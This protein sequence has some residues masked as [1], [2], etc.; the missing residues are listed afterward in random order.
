MPAE[1]TVTVQL[2][3]REGR[4]IEYR[5]L[6]VLRRSEIQ[7]K[8]HRLAGHR[9]DAHP[10]GSGERIIPLPTGDPAATPI[11]RRKRSGL[12][13]GFLAPW[14]GVPLDV[15]DH[16]APKIARKGL[17]RAPFVGDLQ[18]TRGKYL[19]AIP[20]QFARFRAQDHPVGALIRAR[21]HRRQPPLKFH[22]ALDRQRR[23]LRV[24]LQSQR[25]QQ[26]ARFLSHV[27]SSLTIHPLSAL[28]ERSTTA[29][30]LADHR[31]AA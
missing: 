1:D 19:A 3:A 22:R 7:G 23:L 10:L 31:L 25:G 9:L 21:R 17:Q 8:I 16:D 14:R 26:S 6:K 28:A 11:L 4:T 13:S 15:P 29:L 30:Y 18:L 2:P 24:D 20:Q 27:R 12:K 5:L